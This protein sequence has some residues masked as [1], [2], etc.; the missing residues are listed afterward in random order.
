MAVDTSTLERLRALEQ[1]YSSG[2]RSEIIDRTVRKL[3][4]HQAQSDEAQLAELD[5][6]IAQFERTYS[7]SSAEFH[8]KYQ[9]G[10]MG[11]DADVFEWNA[12]Y[13]MRLRLGEAVN[14]LRAQLG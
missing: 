8:A 3:L 14:T 1:I 12:L 9:R 4:E 13:E 11:D 6:E 5:A 7:M 2:Y 10:E